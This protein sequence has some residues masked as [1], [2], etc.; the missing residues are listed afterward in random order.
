MVGVNFYTANG[1]VSSKT[2]EGI[3]TQVKSKLVSALKE[4]EGFED[5]VVNANGGL[6]VAVASDKGTG[7]TIFANLALTI[8]DKDPMIKTERKK[9]TKK[10]EPISEVPTLF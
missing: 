9:A 5:I 4:I 2:R 1:N 7:N 10:A 8:N 6:S 3:S